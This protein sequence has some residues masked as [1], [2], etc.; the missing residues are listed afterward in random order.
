MNDLFVGDEVG[1]GTFRIVYAHA[2]DPTLVVKVEQRARSFSNVSEWDLWNEV[3]DRPEL[4]RWFAPCVAISFSGSVLI[5]KRTEPIRRMP[6]EL[7]DFFADIKRPNFGRYKGR[8]VA[9]DYGNHPH[10]TRSFRKWRMRP[11]SAD[12]M[13]RA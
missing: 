2:L 6:A 9:H 3:A 7:P 8:I 10:Y 11:V 13:V 4:A 5:Q 12:D 1:R